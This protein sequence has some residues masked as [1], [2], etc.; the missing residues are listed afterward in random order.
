MAVIQLANVK[1]NY[2]F[3]RDAGVTTDGVT[4]TLDELYLSLSKLIRTDKEIKAV[5]VTFSIVSR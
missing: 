1:I 2:V 5:T 4:T 3:E